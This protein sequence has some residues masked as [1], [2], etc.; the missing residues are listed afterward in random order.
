[1][2]YQ[3]KATT[4][5]ARS[6]VLRAGSGLRRSILVNNQS[7]LD[8]AITN[9]LRTLPTRAATKIRTVVPSSRFSTVLTNSSFIPIHPIRAIRE[10][11]D[12]HNENPK[13][14]GNF[15]PPAVT[16]CGPAAHL[17]ASKLYV[18]QYNS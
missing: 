11:G 4:R 18:T 3:A 10:N 6:L 14:L 1:M 15:V 13:M 2:M 8:S 5:L 9:A 17:F 12:G 7:S 16:L